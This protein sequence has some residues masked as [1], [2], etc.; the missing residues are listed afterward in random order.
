MVT[1]VAMAVICAALSVF[2]KA[3][4]LSLPLL[5]TLSILAWSDGERLPRPFV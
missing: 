4:M 2:A 1:Y 3:G 5:M